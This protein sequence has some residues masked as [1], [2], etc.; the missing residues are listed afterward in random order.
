MTNH[1]INQRLIKTIGDY[2]FRN[3]AP[4]F[5][6]EYS[7]YLAPL[8]VKD[9]AKGSFSFASFKKYAKS[10]GDFFIAN[11]LIGEEF[12][13]GLFRSI[14]KELG[15]FSCQSF[16]D[17]IIEFKRKVEN[18]NYRGFE[19]DKVSEDTLRST[20]CIALQE[21]A[22]C[23][24]RTSSGQSDIVVPS[25]RVIIETKLWKGKEVYNAGLPELCDYLDKANYATGYYIVFDYSKSNNCVVEQYGESFELDI[26]GKHIIV[27][28]VLM[29]RE[30]P[31]KLY[32]K[33][34]KQNKQINT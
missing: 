6:S 10:R 8:V 33:A 20:L 29:N 5:S 7:L 21:E 19:K 9:I 15:F 1:E 18:G 34:K 11:N 22:F 25:E 28:F 27:V 24:A 12:C 26:N 14:K 16:K 17:S 3:N 32:S 31:S 4:Y 23:E 30:S 2:C 13:K